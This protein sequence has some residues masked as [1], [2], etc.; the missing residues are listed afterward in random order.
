MQGSNYRAGA[1]KRTC[2]LRVKILKRGRIKN[3]GLQICKHRSVFTVFPHK[4]THPTVKVDGTITAIM[5]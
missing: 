4:F 5:S 1:A 2:G 3:L